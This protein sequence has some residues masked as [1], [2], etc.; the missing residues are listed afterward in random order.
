VYVDI[1]Y[2]TDAEFMKFVTEVRASLTSRMGR[3]MERRWRK[4]HPPS[5]LG[6]ERKDSRVAKIVVCV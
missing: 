1:K 4:E 3:N 5:F 6:V 2:F